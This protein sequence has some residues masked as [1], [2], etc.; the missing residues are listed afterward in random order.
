M[1]MLILNSMQTKS[2]KQSTQ[3]QIDVEMQD[4]QDNWK[5]EMIG[6]TKNKLHLEL[7]RN[8]PKSLAQSWILGA[9]HN[10]WKRRNGIK[11][12]EPPNCQSTFLEF[13]KSVKNVQ[14]D[15]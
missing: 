14:D 15:T 10:E 2:S 13:D 5:E 7:L 6:V 4:Q 8:G 12:P 3:Q 9:L 11:D 1:L